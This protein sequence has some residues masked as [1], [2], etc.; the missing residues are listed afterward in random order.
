[1]IAQEED[2][3]L[4]KGAGFKCH[5]P[6]AYPAGSARALPWRSQAARLRGWMPQETPGSPR[7]DQAL[8]CETPGTTPV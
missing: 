8:I 7:R 5:V 1:M 2:Q 6:L 3:A 4:C